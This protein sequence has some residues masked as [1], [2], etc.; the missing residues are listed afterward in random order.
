MGVAKFRLVGIVL[1]IVS[2]TL[3]LFP[4]NELPNLRAEK[5]SDDQFQV[6]VFPKP[7][8]NATQCP[9][10][11]ANVSI[12]EWREGAVNVVRADQDLKFS[13][14]MF[15]LIPSANNR[16][17]MERWRAEL[18]HQGFDGGDLLAVRREGN[19]WDME[20]RLRDDVHSRISSFRYVVNPDGSVLPL[21]S[22]E[23]S[24]IDEL[25]K[26]GTAAILFVVGSVL[27]LSK[28][29]KIEE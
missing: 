2:V 10:R 11:A 6:L 21:M 1:V 12:Q 7:D 23:H 5:Q 25:V 24:W 26:G 29:A 22:R 16:E 27:V 8:C 20:L 17:T 28:R 15:T 9:T 19:V 4:G 13:S 3:F 18:V 14:A